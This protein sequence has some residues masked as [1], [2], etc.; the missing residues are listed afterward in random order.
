MPGR[1]EGRDRER[2][3]HE[4]HDRRIEEAAEQQEQTVDQQEEQERRQVEPAEPG[5]EQ[6]RDLLAGNDVVEDERAADDQ[7]DHR[8]GVRRVDEDA[9]QIAGSQRPIAEPYSPRCLDTTARMAASAK[10]MAP[11]HFQGS[12]AEVSPSRR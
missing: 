7:D 9:E 8:R 4:Q 12:A 1:L 5:R 6:V 11:P 3:Q 2:H 10:W